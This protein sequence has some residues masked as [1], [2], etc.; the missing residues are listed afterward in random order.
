MKYSSLDN[1]AET[2]SFC[3]LKKGK[4]ENFGYVYSMYLDGHLKAFVLLMGLL[5]VE[6]ELFFCFLICHLSVRCRIPYTRYKLR[7]KL[8]F[9]L[10]SPY[11]L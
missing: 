8:H 2:L 5:L 10:C 9:L 6:Y 4:I 11:F 3:I 7:H 1:L